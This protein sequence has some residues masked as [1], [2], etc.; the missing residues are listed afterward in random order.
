MNLVQVASIL[1]RPHRLAMMKMMIPF[2]IQT[3][4]VVAVEEAVQEVIVIQKILLEEMKKLVRTFITVIAEIRIQMEMTVTFTMIIHK[5]AIV[6]E[7]LREEVILL[8]I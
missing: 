6:M 5:L 2:W 8:T 7:H 4:N 3:H 1:L